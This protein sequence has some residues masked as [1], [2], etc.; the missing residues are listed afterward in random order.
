MKYLYRI[1][2]E[3]EYEIVKVSAFF[4]KE[5]SMVFLVPTKEFTTNLEEKITTNSCIIEFNKNIDHVIIDEVNHADST[6]KS[7]F[8]I[9]WINER[10]K[11]IYTISIESKKD[12]KE[13]YQFTLQNLIHDVNYNKIDRIKLTELRNAI[14]ELG[15]K[16][17]IKEF[18]DLCIEMLS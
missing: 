18:G 14:D 3:K 2:N 6:N 4:V 13:Q 12:I 11:K 1:K 5:N 8:A 10:D 7:M 9:K 17:L 15:T 16:E